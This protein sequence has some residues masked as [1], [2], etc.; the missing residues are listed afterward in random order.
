MAG[1]DVALGDRHKARETRFGGKQVVTARVEL[2]LLDKITNRE[3]LSIR[4]EEEAELHGLGHGPRRRF[5]R[6][7]AVVQR[8]GNFGGLGCVTPMTID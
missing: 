8:L 6:R 4:V 2:A 3:E 5:Q 1:R 7:K